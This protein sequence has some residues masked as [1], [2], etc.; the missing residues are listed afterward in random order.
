MIN[1]DSKVTKNK[2]VTMLKTREH[3]KQNDVN[4]SV[5]YTKNGKS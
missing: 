5:L 2:T 1:L 3:K 4:V